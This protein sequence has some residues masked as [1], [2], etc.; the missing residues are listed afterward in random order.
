MK[1]VWDAKT[2]LPKVIL[3]QKDISD[4]NHIREMMNGKF[5]CRK[6]GTEAENNGWKSLMKYQGVERKKLEARV[7]G[8][9]ERNANEGRSMIQ[10]AKLVGFDHLTELPENIL[11]QAKIMMEELAPKQENKNESTNPYGD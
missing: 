3:D 10:I 4:A 11:E 5:L 1:V 6:C 2:Q 9:I 7:K 8:S